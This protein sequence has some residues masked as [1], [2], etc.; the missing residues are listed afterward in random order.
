MDSV[1]EKLYGELRHLA[2][3]FMRKERRNHTLT[4]TELFHEAYFRVQPRLSAAAGQ[5]SDIRAMFAIAMRRVLIDYARK[6]NRRNNILPRTYIDPDQCGN[7]AYL[8]PDR[9]AIERIAMLEEVFDEFSR[10][11]PEHAKIVTLKIYD[12][13]SIDKI[14]DTLGL[15]QATIMRRWALAKAMLMREIQKRDRE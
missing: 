7:P 14:A 8:D 9:L 1:T 10:Q 2:R 6:R 3:S 15:S 12:Q 13:L 4:P 11:Y 5:V